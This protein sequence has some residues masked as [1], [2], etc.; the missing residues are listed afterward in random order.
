MSLVGSDLVFSEQF[1][2]PFVERCC[3]AG[4]SRVD[5]LVGGPC[6]EEESLI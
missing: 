2:Q 4:E 3:R 5:S 1:S 6:S